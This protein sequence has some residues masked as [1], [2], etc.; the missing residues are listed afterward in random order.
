MTPTNPPSNPSFA[1]LKK[2]H[3]DE[4]GSDVFLFQHT[5]LGCPVLAI[6]N[7]DTNKTFGVAFNTIPTDST[8]VAHILEHSVLMGSKK[9]PIKDVFGEL[10]K[11][12]LMTFLNAMT[13]TDITYYP[14]ATRNLKEYFNLMDVYCDVVFHPLLDRATFEQEGCHFHR[15]SDQEPVRF[16]GVVY[17][18]MKGAYSDP[19]RLIFHHIYNG[20]MPGSTYAHESGGDPKNIPNLSYEQFV[21]FH[22]RHYHP[23]N[24]LFFLYGNAP[25][26]EELK[27]LQ[28]HFLS[29]Y[30]TG[31]AP[32]SPELGGAITTPKH[33]T[34]YYSVDTHDTGEKTYLA[35]GTKICEVTER[36]L[37]T[38]FKIIAN[39]L[40]NSD[41]S[42]LKNNIV[43]SGLCKDFGGFYVSSSSPETMMVCYLIG[44]ES[45]N[46]EDFLSL[47]TSVL[48]EMA[49]Q[50]IDRDLLLSEL[51]NFEFSQREEASKAQRGLNLIHKSMSAMKY[52]VDPFDV[53]KHEELFATIRDK[54]LNNRYFEELIRSYLVD[55]P[56]TVVV[57]L[58][59][60]SNKQEQERDEEEQRISAHLDTLDENGRKR[61]IS[62]TKELL[63]L[64][65][66]PNTAQQLEKLPQL[67]L[68]DLSSTTFHE[69]CPTTMF[70][71][72]VLINE[73]PTN[74]ISYIDIGLDFSCL[75][76]DLLV[77]LN[78][79][80]N[81][82]CEIGTKKMDYIHFAKELATCTGGLTHSLSTY[83][84]LTKKD[85]LQPIFWLHV[86]CLPEYLE[87]TIQIMAEV[88]SELSLED[89]KR[90]REIVGREYAWAEH[91]VQS[92]GYMLPAT[93]VFS[94][95]SRA[96]RY[97]E[98]VNGVTAYLALKELSSN[99]Q[100][101][102]AD[103]LVKLQRIAKLLFNVNNLHLCITGEDEEISRFSE[104]G[105]SLVKSLDNS[106]VAHQAL[107]MEK[108]VDHEAFITSSEVVF[109][110]QGGNLFP[111]GDGYNGHFE[112]M[113]NY[114]NR[115]YLWNTVRQMGGAYGCFIQFSRFT[116]NLAIISYR[117]P[118]VRKTY[119]TYENI[120]AIINS[121]ELGPEEMEQLIIGTY[122]GFDPHQSSAAK[123]AA[124]RNEFFAGVTA[125]DKAQRQ[126]EI[127]ST[128]VDDL[129][130]FGEPFK[131]LFDKS[132]RTIIGNRAKI[133]QDSDL[134]NILTEL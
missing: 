46:K 9:Y 117:D 62:R 70:N 1:L 67:G 126:E 99:Y 30:S 32:C 97:N 81:I 15:E 21:N 109:A 76:Y 24:G 129:K 119:D 4:I 77:F 103:F 125:A 48:T 92:E 69:S 102:E 63:D 90:I 23:S 68:N 79:F 43:T 64:Q 55:A 2:Q 113:R 128:R 116:G 127:I 25:L 27:Y 133:E 91:H 33:I 58:V 36:E 59:P 84:H 94:H 110:V 29:R 20:L 39:I 22:K 74:R 73:L 134:F 17:N 101:M 19:T 123:G 13:G 95:L 107:Q 65:I 12:G 40:F 47:Y 86:K 114:L 50:G 85:H 100:Q 118:N 93:R 89:R 3:I 122:G 106:P 98:A 49:D 45:E 41:G 8:G 87:R 132:Y 44:S 80:G 112:V 52:N 34:D 31:S 61:I 14:F 96:G 71:R 26:E 56:Q 88:F 78:L 35:V 7:Q 131:R 51:N 16:Q 18:E 38:S 108:H 130:Q 111:G 66:R 10:N 60:D 5:V 42:R 82:M 104:L 120:P 72:Q 53:L 124:A 83:T 28:T 105:S 57:T 54:A 37:N 75:P 6:K 115:D 11:G 121:L